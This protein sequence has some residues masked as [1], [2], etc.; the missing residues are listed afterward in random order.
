M[1]TI[2][3]Y[4]HAAARAGRRTLTV[5]PSAPDGAD[6]A[7]GGRPRPLTME[8]LAPTQSTP[9][10]AAAYCVPRISIAEVKTAMGNRLAVKGAEAARILGLSRN[11]FD[12]EIRS[13]RLFAVRR[14]RS[15]WV[16][17]AALAAWLN[18]TDQISKQDAA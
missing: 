8:Q 10:T 9:A 7:R 12:A 1:G 4:P 6:H 14:G 5:N 2:S 17:A 18:G 15:L 11:K 16:T 13:R 3:V